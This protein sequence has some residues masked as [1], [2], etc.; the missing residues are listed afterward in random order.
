MT[1]LLIPLLIIFLALVVAKL[2]SWYTPPEPPR[3][4]PEWRRLR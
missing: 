1:L 4:D 3:K 2:R